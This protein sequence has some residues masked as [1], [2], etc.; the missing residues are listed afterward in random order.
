MLGWFRLYFKHGKIQGE[1][2]ACIVLE[3]S[4]NLLE[5]NVSIIFINAYLAIMFQLLILTDLGMCNV[6]LVLYLL[7]GFLILLVI[8]SVKGSAMDY[9]N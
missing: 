5:G 1:V 6:T 8:P 2:G 9:L 4:W 3:A 7:K